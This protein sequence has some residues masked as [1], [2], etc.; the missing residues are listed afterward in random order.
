[1]RQQRISPYYGRG[2]V[3]QTDCPKCDIEDGLFI[4]LCPLH[5]SAPQ[6]LAACQDLLGSDKDFAVP[7]DAQEELRCIGCGRLQ[8]DLDSNQCESDDCPRFLARQAITAATK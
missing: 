7:E 3:Q 8:G 6:L 1:M 2:E 4:R 5:Q